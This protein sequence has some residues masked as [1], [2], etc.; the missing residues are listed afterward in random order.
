LGLEARIALQYGVFPEARAPA[1]D[2]ETA[3]G[4]RYGD[5]HSLA[6]VATPGVR[7]TQR[8]RNGQTTEDLVVYKMDDPGALAA[9]EYSPIRNRTLEVTR[10]MLGSVS[11]F[12]RYVGRLLATHGSGGTGLLSA[13]VLDAEF[14][15]VHPARVAEFDSWYA[16]EYVPLLP[17]DSGWIGTHRF[18]VING[19]PNQDNR[20]ALHDLADRVV[21]DSPARANGRFTRGRTRLAQEAWFQCQGFLFNKIGSR[22]VA[23]V[24]PLIGYT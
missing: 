16:E 24:I 20:V 14:L 21:V 1:P 4:E 23:R 13:T 15:L 5:E 9:P 6:R 3:F 17:G 11:G 2:G 18:E 8:Y 22:Q 19:A 7:S 10:T 12:T